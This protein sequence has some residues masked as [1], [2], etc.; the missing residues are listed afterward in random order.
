M[1]IMQSALGEPQQP[2][3]SIMQWSQ[4]GYYEVIGLPPGHMMVQAQGGQIESRQQEI[5][6]EADSDIDLTSTNTATSV[7][8]MVAFQ[9]AETVPP[10]AFIV[11]QNRDSGQ[12]SI[13][14]IAQDG[15]FAMREH[16]G[17]G[18]YEVYTANISAYAIARMAATGAR[19][20]GQT[21]DIKANSNEPVR[22][23][24][25]MSRHLGRL[26][27]TAYFNEK[28]IAGAMIVLVPK[29]PMHNASQFPRDQS[30]SDGTFTLPWIIPGKYTLIGLRDAWEKDWANPSVLNRYLSAGQEIDVTANGKYTA[31]VNV[32]SVP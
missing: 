3:P 6:L 17:P 19:V 20:V 9:G 16:L 7:T 22:L 23:S 29:G 13:A 10:N 30:D 28:P 1:S 31:K 14:Q 24:I 21:I 27:G 26:E 25:V 12:G 32:Q 15:S 5:D 8:G 4:Q 18:R 2:V 11:I